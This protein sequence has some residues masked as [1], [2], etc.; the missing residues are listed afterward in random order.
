V[1]DVLVAHVVLERPG[2]VPVVG[3]LEARC[4][5]E[6]VRMDREGELG[7]FSSPSDHFK[8]SRSRSGTTALGDENVSRF[9]ILAA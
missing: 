1:L 6:H 8:K 5:S 2:I 4:V 7:G 3:E 9:H